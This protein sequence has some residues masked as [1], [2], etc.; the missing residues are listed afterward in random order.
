MSA[1][2]PDVLGA[3][4]H[5]NA[6][7]HLTAPLAAGALTTPLPIDGSG[8][9]AVGGETRHPLLL[10]AP[11]A[12]VDARPLSVSAAVPAAGGGTETVT[13]VFAPY[14]EADSYL[15][16]Y[17]APPDAPPA[18]FSVTL[19][20]E[21]GTTAVP[22]AQTASRV[23]L[24]LVEGI[25]GRTLYALGS[26]KAR[27]RREAREAAAMRLLGRARDGAL[28]RIGAELAVPRFADTLLFKSGNVVSE[29]ARESDDD[30]QRRLALYRRL[31]LRSEREVLRLL[32][33]DGVDTDPNTGAIGELAEGLPAAYRKRFTIADEDNDFAVGIKLIAAGDPSY[34]DNFLEFVR[35]VHLIWPGTTAAANN[36]HSRRFLPAAKRDR[37]DALRS[38][39][40]SLFDFASFAPGP[41]PALAP[42]L[43]AALIRAA[44][45]I[46]AL[47]GPS[48]WPLFRAQ[49]ND[50]GSRYEV[51]LGVDVRRLAAPELTA[52]KNK[53]AALKA[54]D[55][56]F[57]GV[58][59]A[60]TRGVLQAMKPVSAAGDPDG[61][62]LLEPCGLRTVHRIQKPTGAPFDLTY[63]SHF[64][65][66]GLT[67]SEVAPQPAVDVGGWTL[68]TSGAFPGAKDGR[69][70]AY[71]REL[72]IAQVWSANG[73]LSKL[74]EQSGLPKTVTH[75]VHGDFMDASAQELFLYEQSSGTGRLAT[76]DEKGRVRQA[77]TVPALGKSWT[78][79]AAG[80]FGGAAFADVV[81]YDAAVGVLARFRPDGAGGL[82]HQ[83]TTTNF[84]PGWS[85]VVAAKRTSPA[86]LFCYDARRGEAAF[87]RLDNA[88][89]FVQDG[90]LATGLRRQWTHVVPFASSASMRTRNAVGLLFYDRASGDVALYDGDLKLL[91]TQK[92]WRKGW[93]DIVP[94][95]DPRAPA[96]VLVCY[97]GVS[98]RGEFW[99]T[100]SANEL[101]KKRNVSNLPRAASHELEAQY[102]APGDVGSNAA[103]AAGIA[104]AR[105][106][107]T[108]EGRPPWTVTTAKTSQ[109]ALWEK[110]TTQSAGPDARSVFREV[111]LP[112]IAAADV[113]A[114]VTQLKAV[115][116][117]L[118]STITLGPPQSTAILTNGAGAADDLGRLV[119]LLREQQLT[120]ALPLVTGANQVVIVVG[121][122]PLPGAGSNL[123]EQV[124]T[125]F[126]WY[127]VPLEGPRGKIDALGSRTRFTPSGPG[128]SAIVVIGYARRGDTDPYEFRVELPDDALL[129]LHQYEFLMNLLAHAHPAGVRVNTYSIR[130]RHVDWK[131]TGT[132]EPLDATVSR[133]YRG[134]RRL[135]HRG[136]TSVTVEDA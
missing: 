102:H 61:R 20:V 29:V 126:R 86:D 97:D 14:T 31:F 54:V 40:R 37:E 16:L 123:F 24:E 7:E 108:A 63:L 120:S 109:H 4:S 121:A 90:P 135:R 131:S 33:G 106:A 53:H 55:P 83:K 12:P 115:P 50:A 25:L 39:L 82:D 122:I 113:P 75:A 30:Y 98:G 84:R 8:T 99:T 23:R 57:T 92:A 44:R 95:V 73:G 71:E 133:S 104:A 43:A 21:D 13:L 130:R 17:A 107:W 5:R 32:N 49:R 52:M 45:C 127:V 100:N 58:A 77:A 85:H 41:E 15:V 129:T 18:P 22:A 117:Q 93:G 26:E 27:V 6:V 11:L 111:G 114:I 59:D 118:V 69:L 103:L 87:Y 35:A 89:S 128:L 56:T 46:Q 66:F 101:V 112:V 38:D 65:T 64:P 134:F 68:A 116:P 78:H 28:D 88:G 119:E 47:G 48:P 81:F 42:L 79:V 96:T 105:A 76:V 72:G 74:S 91:T 3:A 19:A 1:V 136:E 2:H 132:A 124:T 60:E 10:V 110:A 9:A 125:G 70:F 62:W 94:V 51:G 34:R 36:A 80:R 67:V